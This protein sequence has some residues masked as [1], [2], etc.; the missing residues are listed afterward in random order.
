MIKLNRPKIWG[1]L[2]ILVGVFMLL[3]TV[4]DITIPFEE[5]FFPVVF[6]MI[7]ISFFLP[8]E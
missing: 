1:V 6:I 2:F 7:G 5:L 3:D 4:F 8:K